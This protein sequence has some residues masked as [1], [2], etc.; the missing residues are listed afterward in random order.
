[1]TDK[2]FGIMTDDELRNEL[3]KWEQSVET[4]PGWSSAYFAAC[5][6]KAVVREG[7]QR[8]L[9][10]RNKYPI[11]VGNAPLAPRVAADTDGRETE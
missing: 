8:G 1:M 7:I 10:F 6:L 2:P 4:A 9:P 11:R 5:Q 3:A